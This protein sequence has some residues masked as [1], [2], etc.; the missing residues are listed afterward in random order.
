M[1]RVES[2]KPL[3]TQ[4]AV[5]ENRINQILQY[6]VVSYLICR[7]KIVI[8]LGIPQKNKAKDQSANSIYRNSSFK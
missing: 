4:M 8:N 7:I 3:G 6:P 5:S 1:Q 2:L